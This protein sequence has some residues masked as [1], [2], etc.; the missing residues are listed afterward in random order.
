MNADLNFTSIEK[1]PGNLPEYRFVQRIDGDK[2]LDF[3]KSLADLLRR[4]TR[5][6]STAYV[7]EDWIAIAMIGSE[8]RDRYEVR[9]QSAP[10]PGQEPKGGHGLF[11]LERREATKRTG[12]GR[13]RSFWSRWPLLGWLLVNRSNGLAAGSEP[14]KLFSRSGSTGHPG[15][16]LV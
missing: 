14:R 12:D 16:D 2:G 6:I 11:Y 7:P 13:P 10:E 3:I 1:P 15:S 5:Y 8:A 4:G 9:K